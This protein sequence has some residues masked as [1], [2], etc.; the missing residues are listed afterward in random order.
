MIF[1]IGDDQ[2]RGGHYPLFSYAFIAL[3]VGMFFYQISMPYDQLN[4]LIY[5]F[6]SVPVETLNG[7]KIYTAKFPISHA[8]QDRDS[9]AKIAKLGQHNEE[10]LKNELGYSNG[11]IEL[12][13]AN[14]VIGS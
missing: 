3:N 11:E 14:K 4:Q 5:D 10:I 1:P 2:V 9:D 12:L 7:E 6:G 8:E 13:R